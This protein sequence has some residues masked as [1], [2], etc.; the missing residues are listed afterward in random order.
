MSKILSSLHEA[1]ANPVLSKLRE[2]NPG[3]FG[4]D[5]P[6]ETTS[7]HAAMPRTDRHQVRDHF[8]RP[9][10]PA[11]TTKPAAEAPARPA[12]PMAEPAP[13]AQA[14]PQASSVGGFV[15]GAAVSHATEQVANRLRLPGAAGAVATTV[16]KQR[17]EG[18]TATF[19][20]LANTGRDYLL[21]EGIGKVSAAVRP[22]ATPVSARVATGLLNTA[23]K[24]GSPAVRVGATAAAMTVRHGAP[25]IGN[26]LKGEGVARGATW[27]TS[28]IRNASPLSPDEVV[29]GL[30]GLHSNFG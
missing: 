23:R 1:H 17:I 4:A 26:A 7:A 10:L 24:G 20:D 5:R 13:H 9:S 2:E 27:A 25:A 18:K 19:E 8:A 12:E 22:G 16:A 30:H 15:Q 11:A 14:P 6:P 29:Q 21:G 3:G 28:Q